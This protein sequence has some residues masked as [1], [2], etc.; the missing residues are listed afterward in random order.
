MFSLD[1]FFG[2]SKTRDKYSHFLTSDTKV[3]SLNLSCVCLHEYEDILTA[4][5]FSSHRLRL[6]WFTSSGIPKALSIS[7]RPVASVLLR[8]VCSWSSRALSSLW[9]SALE[10]GPS[11][12]S[13]EF[14]RRGLERDVSQLQCS[15]VWVG[16]VLCSTPRTAKNQ[17]SVLLTKSLLG[18]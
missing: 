16:E 6:T 9:P 14:L 12:S 15:L 8:S 18:F 4:T 11:R 17:T 2:C 13:R 3:H 1:V 5:L 10:G 7:S